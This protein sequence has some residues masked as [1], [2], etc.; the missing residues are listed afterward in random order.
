MPTNRH[1]AQLVNGIQ[2]TRIFFFTEIATFI[3]AR[4][5]KHKT[6]EVELYTYRHGDIAAAEGHSERAGTLYTPCPDKKRCH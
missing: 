3:Y 5:H 1:S 2:Y 6:A 4:K